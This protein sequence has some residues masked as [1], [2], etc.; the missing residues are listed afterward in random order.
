MAVFNGTTVML[1]S[2]AEKTIKNP[3]LNLILSEVW[4]FLYN[5]FCFPTSN[6]RLP[7]VFLL[8]KAHGQ[9]PGS[10]HTGNTPRSPQFWVRKQNIRKG[11]AITHSIFT[12]DGGVSW[13]FFLLLISASQ[14]YH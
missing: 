3:H 14:W 8:P 10:L 1:T 12:F 5:I 9:R 6:C 7:N 2:K 11:M 13:F 4:P